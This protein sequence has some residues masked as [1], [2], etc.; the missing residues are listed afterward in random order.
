MIKTSDNSLDFTTGISSTY[1]NYVI[2]FSDFVPDTQGRH[3]VLQFSTD[4]GSSWITTNYMYNQ[5]QY[6][7]HNY[8]WDAG[9]S[10][11]NT[12]IR[13]GQSVADDA[14]RGCSGFV[15]IYSPLLATSRTKVTGQSVY[16]QD[17]GTQAWFS[18]FGGIY[19]VAGA[20]NGFRLTYLVADIDSGN[21]RL[22]GLANS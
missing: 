15:Y 7:F 22:Y 8:A 5:M 16:F 9:Q 2:V 4:A 12:H 14:D 19:N 18:P 10:T 6:A 11:S 20:T 13:I 21:A 3:F 1:E 17:G